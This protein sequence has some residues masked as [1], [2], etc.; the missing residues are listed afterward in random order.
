VVA[1][2]EPLTGDRRPW[3]SR[4][5]IT[6]SEVLVPARFNGPPQSG[7]G[8][9][10]CGMLAGLAP[11][12]RG[13]AVVS[14][15]LPPP[16]ERPMR[17]EVGPD[18]AVLMLG[19]LVVAAVTSTTEPIPAVP[20]VSPAEADLAM[21]GYLGWEDHPFPTCYVCGH[22]R[23]DGLF[24]APGPVAGR[25]D[26][27]ACTWI[28]EETS[29]EVLWGVLDCPGGWTTDPRDDPMVLTRMTADL[30]GT[31]KVGEPH[32][33]V[34]QQV[35]RVGRVA[36]NLTSVYGPDGALVGTSSAEWTALAS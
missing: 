26:T 33:V 6:E 10:V 8:G 28:P 14:L 25:A 12:A 4:G 23:E 27:V 20:P 36:T 34:A 32:V 31:A 3:Q 7:Q 30:V 21:E 18:Q 1:A 11:P 16:L 13:T 22:E 19:E 24:L 9:Y 15:L 29:P 35:R 5:V 17:L 2:P